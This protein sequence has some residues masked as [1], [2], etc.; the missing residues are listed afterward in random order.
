MECK[1][2]CPACNGVCVA[3]LPCEV[4][5]IQCE[6]GHIFAAERPNT[7]KKKHSFKSAIQGMNSWNHVQNQCLL[8]DTIFRRTGS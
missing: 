6:C 7:K 1:F 3:L 4:T 2:L 8:V 5:F